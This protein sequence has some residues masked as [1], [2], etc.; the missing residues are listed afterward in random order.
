MCICIIDD[1][2]DDGGECPS[3][4][5]AV[6]ACGGFSCVRRPVANETCLQCV[7]NCQGKL[8]VLQSI[9]VSCVTNLASHLYIYHICIYSR[10]S[11]IRTLLFSGN[12]KS[13]DGLLWAFMRIQLY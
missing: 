6:R 13:M 7:E 9:V 5:Y 2:T 10:L 3:L 12:D 4:E 8:L 1:S 11:V